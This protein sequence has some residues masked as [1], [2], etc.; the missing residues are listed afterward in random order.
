MEIQ[1]DVD[2]IILDPKKFEWENNTQAAEDFREEMAIKLKDLKCS[3]HDTTAGKLVFH[4]TEESI[5]SIKHIEVFACCD[6]FKNQ[7]YMKITEEDDE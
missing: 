2:G 4:M 6:T 1:F 7:V 3:E 5:E